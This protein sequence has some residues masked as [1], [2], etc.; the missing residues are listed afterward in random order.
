MTMKKIAFFCIPAHGHTNPMLPVAAELVKRGNT[1]RFYSFDEFGEKIMKT[2]AE[3]ISCERFLGALDQRAEERLKAVS[4]TEMTMRSILITKNMDSFLAEEMASFCPD[5]IYTDSV[6]FWGKLTAWKHQ[7]PMVVSTSTFAFNQLSSSYMKYSGKELCD[8]IFGIS[9]IAKGLKELKPL[10]Y[11]VK[12]PLDLIQ[13]DNDTDTVVYTSRAF[14]PFGESFSKHYAFC[15][16]SVFSKTLPQKE[17]ER[18]L[19]YIALG[20][21]INDRPDFYKQCVDGLGMLDIDV[22]ISCG[23]TM[24]I[25]SLGTLPDNVQVY[26]R[27]DQVEVLAK[28]DVFMTHCGM[29][30]VSESLYMA[31]PMVLYPQTGE[32]AA[33]AKRVLEMGAGVMLAGDS[34]D[35][36]CE[37]VQKLLHD[38]H[39]A[40]Q[41]KKC[42][43]DFRSCIGTEGAAEFIENASHTVTEEDFMKKLNRKNGKTTFLYWLIVLCLAVLSG[44][45]FG[46]RYILLIGI[47]EGVLHK[48]IFGKI[49]NKNYRTLVNK[50]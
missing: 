29:N 22:V 32:Q 15:G 2:G 45:F 18:P 35:D 24:D 25:A 49:Q 5:V 43:E 42:C 7:I 39:Y 40:E 13:N 41:A 11:V 9:K 44:V 33:V 1:V 28:A 50:K 38:R 27:V 20:T 47:L 26:P 36:I 30:S 34:A 37:A 12:N 46:W 3:F 23:R 19:I 10:G 17:K 31:T 16:P 8:M 4:G 48:P 6:C 21:V 14:Q